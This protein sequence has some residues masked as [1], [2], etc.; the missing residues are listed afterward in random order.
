MKLVYKKL[1]EE[2]CNMATCAVVMFLMSSVHVYAVEFKLPVDDYSNIETD[3]LDDESLPVVVV[4]NDGVSISTENIDHYGRPKKTEKINPESVSHIHTHEKKYIKEKVHVDSSGKVTDEWRNESK[5]VAVDRIL[6]KEA[7]QGISQVQT[8][9]VKQSGNIVIPIGHALLNRIQTPFSKVIVRTAN[10]AE[11]FTEAGDVYVAVAD[12]R[13]LNLILL[14]DGVPDSAVSVTLVP[15]L[16]K[17]PVMAHLHIVFSKRVELLVRQAKAN[18]DWV[19]AEGLAITE[20]SQ[21][22]HISVIKKIMKPLPLGESPPGFNLLDDFETSPT[23]CDSEM[24]ITEGQRLEGARH[25]IG[26]YLV[27][28][29][30]SQ[31]A[32]FYEES[33][34]EEQVIAV[35]V[36]PREV[37]PPGGQTELY[38]LKSKVRSGPGPINRSRPSLLEH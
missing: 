19:S 8:Y 12:E 30:T 32:T 15:K 24:M 31:A 11:V 14:E 38:I 23:P 28:N 4:S 7:L 27:K 37:I 16:N 13:P 33:C 10:N 36:Y 9:D 20:G 26:V 17:P 6:K 35:A 34:Y 29:L 22:D 18:N 3:S 25:T 21:N 5:A 1:F 2:Y